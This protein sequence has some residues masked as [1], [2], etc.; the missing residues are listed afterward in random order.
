ML[1]GARRANE[2]AEPIKRTIDVV[3]LVLETSLN[4]LSSAD[5]RQILT[6]PQADQQPADLS[7]RTAARPRMAAEVLAKAWSSSKGASPARKLAINS[8]K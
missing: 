1:T 3:S 6:S 4:G 8:L 2:R 5:R 7:P